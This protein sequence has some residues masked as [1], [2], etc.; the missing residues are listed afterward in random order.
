MIKIPQNYIELHFLIKRF[1]DVPLPLILFENYYKEIPAGGMY[2]PPQKEHWYIKDQEYCLDKGLLYICTHPSETT[3]RVEE[4]IAHEFRHHWQFFNLK[5]E[6][7]FDWFTSNLP[8]KERV[9]KYFIKNN[10]EMDALLFSLDIA[11][12]EKTKLWYSWIKDY[13]RKFKLNSRDINYVNPFTK[14][15]VY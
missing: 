13:Y 14:K 8:Y 4:V 6:Y 15:Y 9:I 10:T 1:K 2:L 5:R 3:G 11:P 7:C 12:V